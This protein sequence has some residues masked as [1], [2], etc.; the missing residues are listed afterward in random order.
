M[1]RTRAKHILSN[2]DIIQAFVDGKEIEFRQDGTGGNWA[3]IADPNF[4][5]KPEQYRIKPDAPKMKTCYPTVWVICRHN[6]GKVFTRSTQ[7]AA[8]RLLAKQK[9][10]GFTVSIDVL[11]KI[12]PASIG[13]A[14]QKARS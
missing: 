12:I 10:L 2:I 8:Y 1:N 3:K 4:N 6:D 14:Q 11:K 7:P 5:A 9:A 13:V